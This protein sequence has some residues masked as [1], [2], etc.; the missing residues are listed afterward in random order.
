MLEINNAKYLNDFKLWLEFNNGISGI[1]DLS[2]VLWGEMFEPLKDIKLFKKFKI[3]SIMK[4]IEWENGADLAP[5]F[6]LNKIN[7]DTH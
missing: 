6:L 3:S 5:E 4:T 1:A 2:D 7:I